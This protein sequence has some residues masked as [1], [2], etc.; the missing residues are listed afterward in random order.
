[1]DMHMRINYRLLYDEDNWRP[2]NEIY[3]HTGEFEEI[4]HV[5][6]VIL[7]LKT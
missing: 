2:G 4:L 3:V 5:T 7:N 1:M 6:N